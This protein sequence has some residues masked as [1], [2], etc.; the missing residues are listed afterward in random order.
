MNI[1]TTRYYWYIFSAILWLASL[2]YIC[3]GGL[4]L[5]IDFT[6]GSIIDL[7][8]NN[9]PEVAEINKAI[10]PSIIESATVIPVGS[11][12]I[13]IKTSSLSEEKHQQVLAKIKDLTTDKKVD[14][15]RFDSIG[16]VV[17][18]ELKSKSLL[19]IFLVLLFIISYIAFAFRKVSQPV[20]SWKFGLA[21]VVALAHDVVIVSGFFA[22]LGY[23]FGVQIDVLFITAMLTLLG[24]SV[25][26]TIVTFDRIRENLPRLAG[27]TFDEIIN[28]SLEQTI[29][30]SI[31]TTVTTFLAVTAVYLFGGETTKHFTLALMAGLIVGTYSSLFIASPLL[32]SWMPEKK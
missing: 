15:L 3:L 22:F 29:V 21:A 28:T 11:D 6:G 5:S 7:K 31:N 14:E 24:F 13:S 20:P 16:P 1:I 17:G 2:V 30:R 12:Q 32:Y 26:D 25:H 18:S 10:A 9:R 8:F 23:H 27:K 4:K 19:S